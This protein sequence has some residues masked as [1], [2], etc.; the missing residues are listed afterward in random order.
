MQLEQ[1]EELLDKLGSQNIRSSQ[2]GWVQ[3]SCPFAPYSD[4]HKNRQ[5]AHPSF[6]VISKD[7]SEG[8]SAYRCF[9]C[10]AKGSLSDLILRL[11]HLASQEGEDT[12]AL[13][14]LLVWV[15]ANDRYVPP[16]PPT[17]MDRLEA[18]SYK[19]R[20]A[21][22]IGGIK[23]SE[24]MASKVV[25]QTVKPPEPLSEDALTQLQ[26]LPAEAREYLN[27]T[28]GISP[29]LIEECGFRWHSRSRRI[30]IP[31]RDC[32]GRLVGISGRAIDPKAK[33]KFLHSEGFTRDL[34]LYGEHRLTEGSSGLGVVVE[35][36]F[37]AI[38]LWQQGYDAVAIF[39]TYISRF[40][41]EKLARF[42]GSIVILPD[43]DTAG[44]EGASRMA[45]EIAR[46]LPV[47]IAP[48]PQGKDPDE[49]SPLDLSELLGAPE[50]RTA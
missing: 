25:R 13:S 17:L 50:R 49:L 36:F 29:K 35:G 18:A 19:P 14:D 16:E 12:A 27:Q 40:Q 42:F 45:E 6:G 26:P 31:I 33:P 2:S 20:R 9:T 28:R 41:T 34:Y 47:R 4:K 22:E 7:E 5:D 38:F 10:N 23:M 24:G 32:K 48:I 1:I 3:A 46:K 11:Q 39:G 21:I 8:R 15:Q 44:L 30:A 37:D 43:G